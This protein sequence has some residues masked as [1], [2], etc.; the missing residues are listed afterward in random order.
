MIEAFSRVIQVRIRVTMAHP[1]F[2]AKVLDGHF[3]AGDR[4]GR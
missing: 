3:C 1:I 2:G 4:Q